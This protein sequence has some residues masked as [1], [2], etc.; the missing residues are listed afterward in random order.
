M[1]VTVAGAPPTRASLRGPAILLSFTALVATA[2]VAV[3]A[4]PYFLSSTHGAGQYAG[5]RGALLV[6]I[7]FGMVALFTGPVQ[8]WLGIADRR[9]NLH[10]LL[11]LGYIGAVVVSAASAYWIALTPSAG[12]VFGIGLMGLA[13][14]WL[15]TTSL[16][17]LAIKRHLI[18]QHKEWMI[19]SYVVTFGFV[20]FRIG[21]AASAAFAPAHELEQASIMA[22]AAWAIPLVFTE[23]ILQGRK[24]LRVSAD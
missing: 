2:F 6:H 7:G 16:A 17:F 9:Q 21:T 5:R 23:V 14:A 20:F 22:W 18:E 15:A 19:R 1:S 24:I 3:A 13:T 11:G 12:W 8:L 4:A 10:R